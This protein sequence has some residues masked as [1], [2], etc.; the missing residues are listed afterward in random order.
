MRTA[1]V[2]NDCTQKTYPH[3]LVFMGMMNELVVSPE[4]HHTDDV[5]IPEPQDHS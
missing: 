1:I 5:K 2:R 4:S 3:G